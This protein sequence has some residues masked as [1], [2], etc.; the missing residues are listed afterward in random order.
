MALESKIAD[1]WDQV[2]ARTREIIRD[3]VID[4]DW[5][6]GVMEEAKNVPTSLR[7]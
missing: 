4:G 5:L 7:R 2:A 3:P 6:A 1:R